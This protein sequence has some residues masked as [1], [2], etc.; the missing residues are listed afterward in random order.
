MSL[1]RRA[2]RFGDMTARDQK[3]PG[4]TCPAPRVPP[5]HPAQRRRFR[6]AILFTS[7]RWGWSPPRSLAS[8]L[9]SGFLCFYH[10]PTERHRSPTRGSVSGKSNPW[11]PFCRARA[12]TVTGRQTARWSRRQQEQDSPSLAAPLPPWL[13][14]RA[15]ARMGHRKEK[16][17]RGKIQP[18]SRL[19]ST[20]P[21][22]RQSRPSP[23][24]VW[25]RRDRLPRW[26]KA[27][28]LL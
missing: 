12:P 17:V 13:L 22:A 20:R 10:P 26:P 16:A 23:P 28:Q 21:R 6:P 25:R 7:R 4:V 1:F 9:A 18:H 14:H 11:R 8:S 19:R 5:A 3:L 15:G 24:Q 27:R 2:T